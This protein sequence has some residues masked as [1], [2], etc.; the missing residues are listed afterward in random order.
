MR[1][2]YI[3]L[4]LLTIITIVGAS[5][6]GSYPGAYEKLSKLSPSDTIE[7]LNF[8]EKGLYDEFSLLT[9]IESE[10]LTLIQINGIKCNIQTVLLAHF[11]HQSFFMKMVGL[12]TFYNIISILAICVFIIF[13][14]LL[15]GDIAFY[16]TFYMGFMFL[17][18]I[19]N[20]HLLKFI[21]IITSILLLGFKSPPCNWTN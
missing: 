17:S 15:F 5:C 13:I 1:L 21:G 8:L 7:A 20:G 2:Q 11:D 10:N 14:I 18:L 6:D 3:I 4:S 19:F 12:I 16:L 9:Q